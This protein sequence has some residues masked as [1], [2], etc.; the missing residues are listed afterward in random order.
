MRKQQG[1]PKSPIGNLTL[2]SCIKGFSSKG[3]CKWKQITVNTQ[4]LSPLFVAGTQKSHS[5]DNFNKLDF[6]QSD[7]RLQTEFSTTLE[8]QEEQ[9]ATI[10][11]QYSRPHDAAQTVSNSSKKQPSSSINAWSSSGFSA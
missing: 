11:L 8:E 7:Y 5:T 6:H 3:S 4:W 2:T 1:T 10:A 9:R